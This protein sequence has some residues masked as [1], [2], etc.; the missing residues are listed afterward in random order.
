VNPGGVDAQ[1]LG[2]LRGVDARF[3]LDAQNVRDVGCETG[4]GLL[5]DV[6]PGENRNVVKHHRQGGGL[7]H[8]FEMAVDAFL[9]G[10]AVTGA[11]NHDGVESEPLRLLRQRD[12]LARRG[13]TGAADQRHTARRGLFHRAEKLLPFLQTQRVEFARGAADDQGVAE[14]VRD[15][16]IDQRGGRA[17]VD[18]L[19]V[20]GKGRRQRDDD[21]PQFLAES[22]HSV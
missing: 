16:V 1:K 19:R 21:R 5:L 3:V 14:A 15:D 7:G 10:L 13:R 20:F 8:G 4:H 22:A 12:G 2:H 11:E 9:G 6:Q 17:V 18:V